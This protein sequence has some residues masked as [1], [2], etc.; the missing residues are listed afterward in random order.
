V[1]QCRFTLPGCSRG[2]RLAFVRRLTDCAE[3]SRTAG[4]GRAIDAPYAGLVERHLERRA[5]VGRRIGHDDLD[6]VIQGNLE[7]EHLALGDRDVC[8]VGRL[9][10][11]GKDSGLGAEIFGDQVSLLGRSVVLR[12]RRRPARGENRGCPE[13]DCRDREVQPPDAGALG[14]DGRLT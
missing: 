10:V 2:L 14:D 13:P 7:V 6:R 8:L 11:H 12:T 3:R 1:R 9:E 5:R 4:T